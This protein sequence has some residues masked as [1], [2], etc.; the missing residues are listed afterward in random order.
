M[1]VTILHLPDGI[2]EFE[3][4]MNLRRA[5]LRGLFIFTAKKNIPNK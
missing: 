3:G 1:K 2:H 4:Y 5:L